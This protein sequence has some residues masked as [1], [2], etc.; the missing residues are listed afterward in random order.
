MPPA[1]AEGVRTKVQAGDILVSITGDTG[2]VAVVPWGFAEG[3]INQH[4]AL[5]RPKPEFFPAFVARALSAPSLREKL[6]GAQRGI[7]NSLGLDDIRNILIPL[8][9]LAEQKRIVAKVDE[10][11]KLCDELEARQAKQRETGARLTKSALDALATA[12]G[13]AELAAAWER[14][15]GNFEGLIGSTDSIE[16]LRQCIFGLAFSG[17]LVPTDATNARPR[18]KA[19]NLDVN[20]EHQ[21]APPGWKSVTLDS[22]AE[23]RLGKMLDQHKNQGALFPYL[24]NTNV[25]WLRFEL[26]DIKEMRFL[27]NELSEYEVLPGDVLVCEGGHGIA[28]SA[29]WQGVIHQ[30]MFQKALHRIRPNA[31]LDSHFL[32]YRL[33]NAYDAG[34]LQRYFTGAGILDL[35]GRALA[36]FSFLLPPLPEQKR[37]VAK[38]DQLMALCDELESKLRLAEETSRKVAEALV[39]ELLQG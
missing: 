10:L 16:K 17:R 4:I 38:V 29:V 33:K 8:P 32:A 21:I 20:N 35:T 11:M 23:S 18:S 5:A 37:I 36:R 30:I 39:A 34:E 9:P 12:E 27:E 14:V 26:D 31:G 13:P 24:R 3:F 15:V 25:H 7:K 22:V 28:R 2:M 6:R 1:N 19:Q